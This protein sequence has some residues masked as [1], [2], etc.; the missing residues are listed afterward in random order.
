[1]FASVSGDCWV[2]L[3]IF[4]RVGAWAADVF[5]LKR[6]SPIIIRSTQPTRNEPLKLTTYGSYREKNI[7]I[8]EVNM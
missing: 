6:G 2:S 5:F 4:S 1:M 7:H 8:Y 3:Y